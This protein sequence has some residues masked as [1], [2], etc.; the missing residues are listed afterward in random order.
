MK[1]LN[2]QCLHI[3]GHVPKCLTLMTQVMST[4]SDITVN[5]PSIADSSNCKVCSEGE[6]RLSTSEDRPSGVKVCPWPSSFGLLGARP[7]P[8]APGASLFRSPSSNGVFLPRG[9]ALWAPEC[10]RSDSD[11]ERACDFPN[12]IKSPGGGWPAKAKNISSKYYLIYILVLFSC[13][14][15]NWVGKSLKNPSAY[16]IHQ[17]FA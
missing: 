15:Q 16:K 8:E 5:K 12:A 3:S 4:V 13:L 6:P 14:L 10:L 11:P 7:K 2:N 17:Q 1:H 9:C